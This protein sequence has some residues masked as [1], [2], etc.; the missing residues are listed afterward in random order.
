MTAEQVIAEF[1]RLPP[2]EK[3]AVILHVDELEESMIP[4]SF[5]I[6]MEEAARGEL[7]EM[8]D[9]HFDDPAK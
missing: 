5:R 7:I 3:K 4:E 9:A 8:E 6:G 2:D 1:N